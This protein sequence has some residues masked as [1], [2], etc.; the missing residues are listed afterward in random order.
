MA[1]GFF[2]AICFSLAVTVRSDEASFKQCVTDKVAGVKD[3]CSGAVMG[4]C[5]EV[6]KDSLDTVLD[7]VDSCC[8]DLSSW[9]A[10]ACKMGMS[11]VVQRLKAKIAQH[12]PEGEF[13]TV[14]LLFADLLQLDASDTLAATGPLTE[15]SALGPAAWASAGAVAGAA[16]AAGAM[17]TAG[18]PRTV[19]APALLG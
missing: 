4:Q 8:S 6:C 12:C 14:A 1:K 19:A 7:E 11:Q 2:V 9:K 18:R 3:A 10:M 16:V 13:G 17:C 15:S 5:S